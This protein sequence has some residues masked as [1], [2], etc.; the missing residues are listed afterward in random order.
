[1]KIN[2]TRAMLNAAIMGKLDNVFYEP[3]PY[4]GVQV[5][6]D[7][8]GVPNEVLNARNT[9]DNKEAYDK[10]A[11]HLAGLFEKNFRGYADKCAEEV[12]AAGPK[13]G[14]SVVRV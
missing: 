7:C 10:K 4:F 9:W 3:D 6:T 8:P 11:E 2:H 12:A 14:A 1:M 5:P 13:A